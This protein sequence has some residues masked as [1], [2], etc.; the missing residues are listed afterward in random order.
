MRASGCSET[1]DVS[2]ASVSSP[3]RSCQSPPMARDGGADRAAEIEGE[4]LRARIAA[5][6]QRHERQQHGLAGAGRPDDQR[7]ADIADMKGKPERGRSFGPAVEQR[8][9]AK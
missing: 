6:L 1:E 4:D 8:G 5:E 3:P 2:E 7:M 9:R